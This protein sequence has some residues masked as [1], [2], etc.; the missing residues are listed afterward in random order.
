[1]TFKTNNTTA[2]TIDS[3]QNTTFAG[4]VSAPSAVLEGTADSIL[5]LRST[6]DGPLYMEFERGTDRHA[7]MGFGGSNDTFKIWNEESGGLIQLGTN[8]TE[9]VRIDENQ[10]TIFRGKVELDNGAS[11][12]IGGSQF[13]TD[14]LGG[15][16]D[17]TSDDGSFAF[18]GG[19]TF[20]AGAG[21]VLYGDDHAANPNEIRFFNNAFVER[22]N[23]AADGTL[24]VNEAAVFEGSIYEQTYNLTGSA[25]DAS[26][27][28][29]QYKTLTANTTF[30]NTLVDRQFMTLMIDDGAGYTVTWPSWYEWIGGSAPVLGT[31][32]YN[33]IHLW[34]V[35]S[36]VYA[37]FIGTA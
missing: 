3:S 18:Y 10:D 2:L 20:N 29:I 22:M 35:N 21:V 28:T 30:I 24:T 9:A 16:T 1:M 8:N 36:D 34:R 25:L 14:F 17:G 6:D 13:N 15:S 12:G 7:Y 23:I 32:G 4:P 26:N 33:V 11:F 31:S 27:G 5:T 37:A 19:R